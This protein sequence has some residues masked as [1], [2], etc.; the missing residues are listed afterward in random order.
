[1]SSYPKGWKLPGS[2]EQRQRVVKLF[3]DIDLTSVDNLAAACLQSDLADGLVILPTI[4]YLSRLFSVGDPYGRGYGLIFN[5]LPGLV[6][7]RNSSGERFYCNEDWLRI[8]N[9]A[10]EIIIE[11]EKGLGDVLVLPISF[12]KLYA[13]CT[14]QIAFDRILKELLF[15]LSA[16]QIN[17]LLLLMPERLK[18]AWSLGVICPVDEFNLSGE[19]KWE[20]CLG[21]DYDPNSSWNEFHLP[22]LCFQNKR[23]AYQTF[24]PVV[25]LQ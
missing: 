20:S 16:V 2:V 4:S 9:E 7:K 11:R 1:M 23:R 14:A 25:S 8:N 22:R 6:G 19:G 13:G 15:P 24:G 10:K 18:D 5:R 12:G 17:I 21:F 3:P